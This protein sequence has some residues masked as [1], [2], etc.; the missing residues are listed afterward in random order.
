MNFTLN[1]INSMRPVVR[2]KSAIEDQEGYL[3]PGM[4]A[5]IVKITDP[6]IDNVIRV[7]YDLVEFDEFNMLYEKASYYDKEGHPTLTAREAG[8]YKQQDY[9]YTE[10]T[11]F[12]GVPHWQNQFEVV[13]VTDGQIK[14]I[15]QYNAWEVKGVG[16]V[17][18]LEMRCL[19]VMS[20]NDILRDAMKIDQETMAE[21]SARL[22]ED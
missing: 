7:H 22:R 14:L 15:E 3:E 19:A 5:R 12:D 8:Y 11:L 20:S 16:Y 18:W 21:L 4:L 1:D 10:S 13:P 2:F 6:D 17:R 9:M